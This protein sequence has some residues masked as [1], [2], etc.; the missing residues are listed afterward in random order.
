MLP[1]QYG[2][3]CVRHKDMPSIRVYWDHVRDGYNL[4]LRDLLYVGAILAALYAMADYFW[5]LALSH[6]SVALATSIFNSSCVFVYVFSIVCLKER[7]TLKQACGVV[8]AVVGVLLISFSVPPKSTTTTGVNV[9]RKESVVQANLFVFLGA[10]FYAGYEVAVKFHL[11][12]MEE[13]PEVVNLITAVMGIY[14]ALYWILGSVMLNLVPSSSVFYEPFELPTD[15][16]LI[17]LLVNALFALVFNVC[18]MLALHYTSPLIVSV[19][20]MT[21]IPFTD[22]LDWILHGDTLALGQS[23]GSVTVFLGFLCTSWEF[24]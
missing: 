23:I 21:T 6:T 11:K 18:L 4:S 7:Q 2:L 17:L 16:D 12:R 15:H 19:G 14:S 8:M 20:C 22:L 1:F 10:I 5:Y 9:S 24:Q 3:Y 13:A